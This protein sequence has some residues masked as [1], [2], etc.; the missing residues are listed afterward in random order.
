MQIKMDEIGV[1]TGDYIH[2]RGRNQRET[3]CM[4]IPEDT[5]LSEN[6]IAVNRFTRASLRL[7]PSDIV[8]SVTYTVPLKKSCKIRLD[9]VRKGKLRLGRYGKVG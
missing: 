5:R 8:R 6:S 2:M 4:L 1:K 3:V 9:Q 7:R